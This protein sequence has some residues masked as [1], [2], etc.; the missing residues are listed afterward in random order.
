MC[1]GVME[2]IGEYID[3]DNIT[4][5]RR[6]GNIFEVSI[7]LPSGNSYG[8]SSWEIMSKIEEAFNVPA[9][10][11]EPTVFRLIRYAMKMMSEF[12]LGGEIDSVQA[13]S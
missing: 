10:Q 9:D 6:M 5:A 4:E 8:I 2:I 3:L 12:K 13:D 1:G 11:M 7:H